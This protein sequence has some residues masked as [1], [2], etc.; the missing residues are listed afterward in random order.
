MNKN[1]PHSVESTVPKAFSLIS[2]FLLALCIAAHCR[3][4]DV[5]VALSPKLK[6]TPVCATISTATATNHIPLGGFDVSFT[7]RVLQPGD[8]MTVLGTVSIK[9]KESQWLLYVE[10]QRPTHTTN[11]PPYVL[12]LFG[13]PIKFES[14]PVPAK[15]RMLGPF[16]VSKTASDSKEQTDQFELNESF[17]ALGLE[18]AAEVMHDRNVM[19]NSAPEARDIMKAKLTPQEQRALAGAIPALTSYF[20]IVQH[21]DGLE[22]LLYK[23]VKLPSVWSMV[24]RFGVTVEFNV[25]PDPSPANPTDWGLPPGTPI[26]YLHCMLLLNKQP[27]LKVTLVV[28]NPDPPRLI[29]AGV[30]GL[31]AEKPGDEETYMTMRLV[32]AKCKTQR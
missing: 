24:R 26:Y 2:T 17:L 4:N 27:A 12:N 15:L 31:L 8:S 22:S 9:K 5:Q 20:E 11:P 25:L 16:A 32:S 18:Q 19:T 3:A 23:V 6:P 14:K 28:T 1:A 30:V 10:A 29:C 7:N 21:T 13:S